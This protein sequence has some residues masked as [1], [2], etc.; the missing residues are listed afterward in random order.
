[1]VKAPKNQKEW[2]ATGLAGLPTPSIRAWARI[3]STYLISFQYAAFKRH[4]M[5]VKIDKKI[6]TQTPMRTRVFCPGSAIHCK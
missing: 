3:T 5:K 1:M 6:K 2:E 4:A